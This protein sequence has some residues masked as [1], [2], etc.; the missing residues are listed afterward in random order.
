M[1]LKVVWFGAGF[2]FCLLLNQLHI[3]MHLLSCC[4]T[5]T[6]NSFG[7]SLHF[8][9]KHLWFFFLRC[10]HHSLKPKQISYFF[11]SFLSW[12]WI[13]TATNC[14][15]DSFDLG[16]T[17]MLS[18]V[19]TRN[20][21]SMI[22]IQGSVPDIEGYKDKIQLVPHFSLGC[23]DW[24]KKKKGRISVHYMFFRDE[25]KL[26]S[27]IYRNDCSPETWSAFGTT[28]WRFYY[29]YTRL[30]ILCVCIRHNKFKT[31]T[32]SLKFNSR[33]LPSQRGS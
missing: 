7:S 8:L 24:K 11:C 17:K 28:F 4:F 23:S 5:S 10:H 6:G 3:C 16:I 12:F 27:T 19:S 18:F 15:L 14:S 30:I 21:C 32:I 33:F 13:S 9:K 31:Y 1:K 22:L 26:Q 25:S 20:L 2:F 29:R